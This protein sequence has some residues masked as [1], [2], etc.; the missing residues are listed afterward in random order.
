MNEQTLKNIAVFLERVPLTGKEA[1]VWCEAYGAVQTALALP[2]PVE[3]PP[4]AE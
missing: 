4:A 1:F 2:A 3:P